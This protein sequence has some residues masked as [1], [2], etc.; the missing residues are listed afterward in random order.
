MATRQYI[1]ARYVPKFYENSDGTAAWRSG[2]IYEPLTIVTYNGNSYTSKKVVPA[3]IG[4]PSSNPAYWVATGVY[5]EQIASLTESLDDINNRID[6]IGKRRIVI[7]GDSYLWGYT[8]DDHQAPITSWGTYLVNLLGVGA[9]DYDM[10]SLGGAGFAVAN[11][12]KN[13]LDLLNDST[14]NSP[15]TVTDVIVEGGYNDRNSSDVDIK[16]GILTFV[17]TAKTKYPNAKVWVGHNG[18]AKHG[19]RL[20]SL[21]KSVRSYIA[22]ANEA[23]A[24][25]IN[26]IEFSLHRYF[27]DF[28]ADG[29]HANENGQK[30]IA[31]LTADV[32]QGGGGDI[33]ETFTNYIFTPA[34]D[35]SQTK[36]P[37][38]LGETFNG[39]YVNV[40]CQ[41]PCTI[42]YDEGNWKTITCSGTAENFI[43]L[44]S[45]S[46]GYM[47]GPGDIMFT[48][49]P[50]EFIFR[51][52]NGE[53]SGNH[54]GGL[55]I[56]NG[57]LW[58]YCR[59]T[60]GNGWAV[61][62]NVSRIYL[63]TFNA[64]FDALF[65]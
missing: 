50:M 43:D 18:W 40:V 64:Q 48:V 39:K 42:E 7:I 4:D 31:Q 35:I 16:N 30:R 52:G 5:N 23:G 62:N 21:S 33:Y 13:F 65:C 32:L 28:F 1:G 36:L 61:Y 53:F 20:Y 45:F 17:R 11:L 47:I 63:T 10:R 6:N 60:T 51:I 56:R 58:V 15:E 49:I 44:G 29:V 59:E 26:N 24:A 55:M 8:G 27:T 14:I 19:D 9:G 41:V 25:Y 3:T 12:G 57:H 37:E 22:G 38:F 46:G 2:V 34:S 54:V